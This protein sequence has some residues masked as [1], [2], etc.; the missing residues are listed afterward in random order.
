[1][2]FW[3]L[4]YPNFGLPLNNP[5]VFELFGFAARLNPFIG[6]LTQQLY[7]LIRS[8]Q[9]FRNFSKLLAEHFYFL[10]FGVFV[11]DWNVRNVARH[12]GIRQG[13]YGLLDVDVSWIQASYLQSR[14][15]VPLR[16]SYCHRCFV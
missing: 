11:S 14:N 5:W 7:M 1:V 13:L 9:L 3:P 15:F 6:Q 8:M 10:H 2:I 16:S 12:A 4:Y